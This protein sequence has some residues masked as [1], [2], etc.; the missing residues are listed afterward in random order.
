MLI[1]DD[2]DYTDRAEAG[3]LRDSQRDAGATKP[4]FLGVLSVL[5]GLNLVLK[6]ND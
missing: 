2:A 3:R 6:R 1:T 4:E 5:G